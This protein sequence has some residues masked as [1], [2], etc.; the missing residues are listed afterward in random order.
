MRGGDGLVRGSGLRTAKESA[1]CGGE[2]ELMEVVLRNPF[3]PSWFSVLAF[4]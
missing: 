3:S 4:E 1:V 2:N